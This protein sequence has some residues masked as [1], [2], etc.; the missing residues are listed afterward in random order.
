MYRAD[1]IVEWIRGPNVLDVGCAAHVPEP[2]N[3]YWVHGKLREKFPG[4]TGIDISERNI[5]F[6]KQRGFGNLHVASAETFELPERFDTVFSGE[7]IEHLSNPGTFLERARRHLAEGGRIVLTTPYPFSLLF[8]AYAFLKYPKTCQNLEHTCWFCPQTLTGLAERFGLRVVHWE[9]LEDYRPDDPSWKY[10]WFVRFVSWF[11]W[12]IPKRLRANTMM[13]V[14]ERAEQGPSR[15]GPSRSSP[16]AAS[17][18]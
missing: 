17:A 15:G 16:A 8:Q 13:F 18:D 11:R 3:R 2:G 6:L 7:L 1:A 4:V 12:A 10:R 14:L 5:G 9:L